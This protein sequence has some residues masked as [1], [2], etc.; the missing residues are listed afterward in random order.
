MA[1]AVVGSE[2]D[3][4][5]NAYE[6][7]GAAVVRNVVPLDWLQRLGEAADSLMQEGRRGSNGSAPGRGTFFKDTFSTLDN[8]V[9]A[10]FVR[11]TG[12]AQLAG[13]VLRSKSI[14][15]FYDQLLVKEP[16]TLTPTPWHQDLPYWPLRGEQ[17]LSVWVPMD[18]ATPANGVVTYVKGSHRWKSFFEPQ[19]FTEQ[20]GRQ[21]T[22]N[23]G[24]EVAYDNPDTLKD[25]SEH[26]E[27]YEFIT[28][29]VQPGDV[30]IHHALT[31]HGAAGNMSNGQ[32]RRALAT[33]WLG[34]DLR[35]DD[36]RPN[37]MRELKKNPDFPYPKLNTGDPVIDPL[38][39]EV[40]KAT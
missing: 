34:D 6:T 23:S 16:G 12:L 3:D 13:S 10:G 38:F 24:D 28:W 35:W 11:E 22:R 31:V 30:I 4:V 40:W 36:T 2:L 20:V 17:V 37:F 5:I 9:F 18:P 19:S 8:P 7:D 26:P 29:D 27:R 39:P 32:R 33:R 14:R 25:I 1:R 21:L 15:F